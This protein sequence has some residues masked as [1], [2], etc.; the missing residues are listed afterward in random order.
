[1]ALATGDTDPRATDRAAAA[2]EL[3][4]CASLVHD[5]LPCF[6]DADLRRGRPSV[7]RTFGE[8][9]AVL[10]GDA[11]IVQ[12]FAEVAAGPRGGAL[13]TLLAEAAG[14]VRGLI[15]GQA[16]ESE[17]AVGV[18]VY[19]RAKTASLFEAAAA[20]G[21]TSSGADPGP[22][23]DFGDALGLAYQAADDIADVDGTASRTGKSAGR[24]E[25]LDRPS[26]VRTRG[27]DAARTLAL[28][29]L[30]AAIDAIPACGGEVLVRAWVER[31]AARA[32]L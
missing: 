31:F 13:A 29:K 21:A 30:R 3:L 25:A 9:S 8:A 27:V 32:G 12:A 24:D 23:R 7:H 22:W 17:P 18:D 16:W 14:S 26:L 28:A 10:V 15:A 2:L 1:V 11:L 5:D 4:H 19:H 6:D 20:M